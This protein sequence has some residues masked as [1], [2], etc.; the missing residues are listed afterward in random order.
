MVTSITIQLEDTPELTCVAGRY[1]HGGRPAVLLQDARTGESWGD[2]TVDLPESTVPDGAADTFVPADQ[3]H[4]LNVL[5]D[6]GW[7]RLS[8]SAPT[9]TLGSVLTW[10]ASRTPC[11]RPGSDGPCS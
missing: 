6:R 11:L 5:V 3:G 10:C 8:A 1:S 7:S 9:G 4:Y 2:L